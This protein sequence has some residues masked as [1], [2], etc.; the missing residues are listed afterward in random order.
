MRARELTG[1]S[2][3]LENNLGVD[4]VDTICTEAQLVKE[5]RGLGETKGISENMS[6]LYSNVVT[7]LELRCEVCD[8]LYEESKSDLEEI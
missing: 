6:V 1:S 3:G 8:R 2:D 4:F 5:V 7:R